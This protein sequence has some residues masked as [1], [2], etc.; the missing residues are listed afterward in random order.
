MPSSHQNHGSVKNLTPSYARWQQLVLVVVEPELPLAASAHGTHDAV[1]GHDEGEDIPTSCHGASTQKTRHQGRLAAAKTALRQTETCC[2]PRGRCKLGRS[3]LAACL[4]RPSATLRPLHFTSCSLG[5]L[6]H[7]GRLMAGKT[8][9]RQA[10]TGC[11]PRGRCELG[12]SGLAECLRRSITALRP[13]HFAKQ[14]YKSQTALV[15]LITARH[16][17]AFLLYLA[18]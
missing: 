13:P 18:R 7:C 2:R 15:Y 17:C 9:L 12:H 8:A 4:R 3:D 10:K 16:L 14:L 6:P 1:L 5:K 11:R